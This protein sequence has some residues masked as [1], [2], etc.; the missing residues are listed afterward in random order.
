MIYTTSSHEDTYRA[1]FREGGTWIDSLYTGVLH[2][3][4]R[5]RF[6]AHYAATVDNYV[7]NVGSYTGSPAWFLLHGS[8]VCDIR[9]RVEAAS[10]L[11]A[12]SVA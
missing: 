1:A 7:R 5:A 9:A 2:H 6:A 12:L 3:D 8:D 11:S 10:E 4:D